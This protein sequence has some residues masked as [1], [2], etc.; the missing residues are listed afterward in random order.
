MRRSSQITLLFS[1]ALVTALGQSGCSDSKQ[2]PVPA[3]DP[4]NPF[5]SEADAAADQNK[6]IPNNSYTP[7]LGYYHSFYHGWYPYPFNY[8]FPSFGYYWGGGWNALPLRGNIPASSVPSAAAYQ[9]ARN[10]FLYGTPY[11]QANGTGWNYGSWSHGYSS[12]GYGGGDGGGSSGLS[13]GGFGESGHGGGHG[14]GE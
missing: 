6:T 2:P 11:Y 4:R 3:Y 1:G 10:E 12:G 13:F 14:G 9:R 5:V 8:Y 7:G